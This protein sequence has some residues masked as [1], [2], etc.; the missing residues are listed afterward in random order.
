LKHGRLTTVPVR[1]DGLEGDAFLA[2]TSTM[3]ADQEVGPAAQCPEDPSLKQIKGERLCRQSQRGKAKLNPN[4]RRS[5]SSA[6][7]LGFKIRSSHDQ[8]TKAITCSSDLVR[9]RERLPRRV[10]KG[11]DEVRTS[12]N[13]VSIL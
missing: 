11:H 1:F 12:Y 3:K 13:L 6:R 2:R 8:V 4:D 9:R 10:N 7:R 5:V